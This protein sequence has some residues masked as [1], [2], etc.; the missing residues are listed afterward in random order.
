MLLDTINRWRRNRNRGES[1]S[2]GEE[3]KIDRREWGE[4]EIEKRWSCGKGGL[5]KVDRARINVR[6]RL[7]KSL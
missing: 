5:H 7:I 6:K 3:R 4:A 2:F 1:N